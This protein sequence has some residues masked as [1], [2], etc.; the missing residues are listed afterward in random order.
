MFGPYLDVL[1][2]PGAARFSAAGLLARI[3]LSMVGLGAVM[4]L[5]SVRGSYAVAGVV[6]AAYA[7]S[8]AAIAPQ[9]SRLIDQLGQRRIV[10]IQ[11]SIHVPA[12]AAMICIAVFTP[13]TW[14]IV[15][16]AVLAGSAQPQVG[17][18][19]RT[20]WSAAL[21][22]TP[23]L[24]TAYAWE[25]LLDEVVFIVGPPAATV[26]AVG[27]FPSAA[28]IVAM[29][30]LTLGTIVLLTQRSTEP[31]PSGR[32]QAKGGRPAIGLPGVAGITAIFVLMGGIFGSYEVTTVAFAREAGHG[33]LA[34]LLL[35]MY[36]VGS[37]G[38]GLIFGALTLKASLVRQ[39]IVSVM[40]LAVVT[41]PLPFLGN[42][43]LVGAGLILAGVACSP[44]LISGMA[45]LERVV[46][47]H[48]LTEALSWSFSGM[49]VGIAMATPLAGRVIDTAGPSAAY[50]VTSGCAILA[51]LVGLAVRG[52]L[53]RA[54]RQAPDHADAAIDAS[55]FSEFGAV[56]VQ[57]PNQDSDHRADDHQ[58]PEEGSDRD[59][60]ES[61]QPS[62]QPDV[63]APAASRRATPVAASR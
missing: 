49:A 39:F 10:P 16:L 60:A 20:R 25:S 57:E 17:S 24:R 63:S 29:V 52:T 62:T 40:I 18:L 55:E 26:L 44:A 53:S 51:A 5:S 36:A 47:V 2:H 46:P 7:L 50:W 6:S 15:V 32:Q 35:A 22:G 33:G 48:R 38:A 8:S 56:I 1:R 41:L 4:L 30:L 54:L 61:P 43:W 13:L 11:L 58:E 23:K 59:P 31:V 19:V 42:L 3:P 28:L 37:L 12:V 21:S 9:F 34:G 27:L 45:L 14:P